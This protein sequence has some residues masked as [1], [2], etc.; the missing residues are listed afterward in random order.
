[1]LGGKNYPHPITYVINIFMITSKID[2]HNLE[3][4]KII[5]CI[6]GFTECALVHRNVNDVN[7]K[8]E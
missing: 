5:I 4:L 2:N 8:I 6:G 3:S 7:K 1:M